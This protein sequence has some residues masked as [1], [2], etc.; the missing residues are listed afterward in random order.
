MLIVLAFMR[1][2][3]P[4][5]QQQ[6]P[7]LDAIRQEFGGAVAVEERDIS[8]SPAEAQAWGVQAAPTLMVCRAVP[9]GQPAQV[10]DQMVGK[11]EHATLTAK[12]HQFLAGGVPQQGQ[13]SGPQGGLPSQNGPE[14]FQAGCSF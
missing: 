4:Y 2:D 3:C 7:I 12:L 14:A 6:K 13:T 11:Q 5:C 9:A 8:Q 10:L 1:H